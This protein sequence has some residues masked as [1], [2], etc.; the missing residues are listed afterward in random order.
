MRRPASARPPAPASRDDD[1]GAGQDGKTLTIDG[2]SSRSRR[3]LA[4]TCTFQAD[5]LDAATSWPADPG[6]QLRRRHRGAPDRGV[7]ANLRSLPRPAGSVLAALIGFLG[8]F[9]LAEEAAQ[10]AFAIAAE[11]WPRDGVPA[12]P[13]RMAGDD[14]AQPGDRSH[15]AA[16]ARWPR[17]PGCSR[18]PRRRRTRWTRRPFPTSGSSSSPPAATRRSPSTRRSRST[19]RTLGG[20]TTGEIAARLPGSAVSDDGPAPGAGE[21]QDQSRR[22]SRSGCRP[23]HLLPDRLAAVLA[24][25]YPTS[26]TQGYGGRA[27]H[28][29]RGAAVPFQRGRADA[30]RAGG[31]RP[32][33]DDAAARGPPRGALPR[34]RARPARRPGPLAAGTRRRSRDGRADARPRTGAAGPAVTLSR[35]VAAIPVPREQG[36]SLA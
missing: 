29:G 14:G 3:P 11:R 20:L 23:P 34:R 33:R 8:D 17:R 16:I 27:R 28:G 4:A 13:G 15:P 30:G 7:A 24:V 6:R 2:P 9:D 32:A 12:Q 22:A 19:L 18:C 25:V 36:P 5:D 26:S 1:Y 31:A 10:E 35:M 21:A